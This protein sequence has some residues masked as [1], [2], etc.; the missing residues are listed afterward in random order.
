MVHKDGVCHADMTMT[1]TCHH[2]CCDGSSYKSYDIDFSFKTDL[3]VN[4]YE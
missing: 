4:D 3:A 1:N 2:I